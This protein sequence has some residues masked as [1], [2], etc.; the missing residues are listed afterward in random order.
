SVNGK[1]SADTAG[2]CGGSATYQNRFM[3]TP[4]PDSLMIAANVDRAG[5]ITFRSTF[6]AI[7]KSLLN[8]SESKREQSERQ[9]GNVRRF[10][11]LLLLPPLPDVVRLPLFPR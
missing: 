3:V 6:A 8:G 7:S 2:R 1:T 10:L 11:T 4:W 5:P 9:L